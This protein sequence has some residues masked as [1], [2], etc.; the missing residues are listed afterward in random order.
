MDTNRTDFLDEELM[1]WPDYMDARNNN[2][3]EQMLLRD[4]MQ[5]SRLSRNRSRHNVEIREDMNQVY[6]SS[7]GPIPRPGTN[8]LGLSRSPRDQINL[9]KNLRDFNEFF[10]SCCPPLKEQSKKREDKRKRHQIAI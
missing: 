2:S 8:D 10:Y 6:H 4:L 3:R 7:G 1:L 9:N 5:T